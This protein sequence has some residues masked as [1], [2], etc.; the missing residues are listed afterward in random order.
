MSWSVLQ[1]SSAVATN[2]T[3]WPALAYS[4]NVS[5]GTKLIAC[6]GSLGASATVSTVKDGN[7]NSFTQMA[8]LTYSAGCYLYIYQLD[9][10]AGDAGTK[11]TVNV[12]T[13]A[14]AADHAL[15]IEE[16][17]GLAA[18]TTTAAV[19]D[20]TP[21]TLTGPSGASPVSTGTPSYSSGAAGEF[22]VSVFGT[23]SPGSGDTPTGPGGYTADA[24]N[25]SGSANG[26]KITL[27]NCYANSTGST[28]SGGYSDTFTGTL[29]WGLIL[30][31][32]KLAG[33]GPSFTAPP[34][35]P[36]RRVASRTPA[37]LIYA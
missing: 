33:G 10:P 11:P 21:G 6:I 22:L 13:A 15:I 27:W 3:T 23:S 34:N 20:G 26:G 24:H 12:V 16:V 18:G 5:S 8:A 31:A 9:T 32:F 2:D 17:S 30:V 25:Q 37:G 19:L 28:E 4:S 29:Q 35:R 7:G 36:P 14:N 1:S